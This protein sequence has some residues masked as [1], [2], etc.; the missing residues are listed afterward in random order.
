MLAPVIYFQ[1]THFSCVI[2]EHVVSPMQT[3]TALLSILGHKTLSPGL[4]RTHLIFWLDEFSKT[5][6]G[7]VS[8][9]HAWQ[10]GPSVLSNECTSFCG[11]FLVLSPVW[12][13]QHLIGAYWNWASI[14][15]SCFGDYIDAVAWT[16]T[17]VPHRKPVRTI[18]E[19]KVT[20]G[21]TCL[22]RQRRWS[23]APCPGHFTPRKT[24]PSSHRTGG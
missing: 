1:T 23:S 3:L 5:S 13:A 4:M 24:W 10:L 9:L 14:S 12:V 11:K 7:C 18:T 2:S 8:H 22:R 19:I 16:Y 6:F 21:H 15:H 17:C 20:P